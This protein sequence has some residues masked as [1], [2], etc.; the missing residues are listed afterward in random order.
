M[1]DQL[2]SPSQAL[3]RGMVVGHGKKSLRVSPLTGRRREGGKTKKLPLHNVCLLLAFPHSPIVGGPKSILFRGHTAAAAEA[4]A[5]GG[6]GYFSPAAAVRN[7][8]HCSVGRLY[9]WLPSSSPSEKK[10][11][12]GGGVA[13]GSGRRRKGRR[14]EQVWDSTCWA[15]KYGP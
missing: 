14:R 2:M 3:S 13:V 8:H 11:E 7:G 4:A 9:P 15:F 1:G 10:G 6:K 12:G 5:A